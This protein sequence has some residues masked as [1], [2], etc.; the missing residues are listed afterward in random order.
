MDDGREVG[1]LIGWKDGAVVGSMVVGAVVGPLVEGKV[2]GRGNG[3]K[4]V[5]FAQRF[6]PSRGWWH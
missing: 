3:E 5:G 4:L 2:L 1:D 6:E